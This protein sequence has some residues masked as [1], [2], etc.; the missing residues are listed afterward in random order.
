MKERRSCQ[1]L[2][3]I[4]ENSGLGQSGNGTRTVF[5]GQP[6]IAMR[7]VYSIVTGTK[8]DKAFKDIVITF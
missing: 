6:A 2:V 3:L 5:A 8:G 7:L 1:T 4:T